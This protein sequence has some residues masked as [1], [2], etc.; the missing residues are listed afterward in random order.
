MQRT[1]EDLVNHPKLRV[2]ATHW[3]SLIESAGITE[4]SVAKARATF[5]SIAS[6]RSTIRSRAQLPDAVCYE[7][8]LSVYAHHK[9][10]DSIKDLIISAIRSG[11]HLTAYVA[12]IVIRAFSSSGAS[13][14]EDA[15]AIFAQMQD[16]P[17]GLAASGNHGPRQRGAGNDAHELE[18]PA[19]P[20]VNAD[21]A[22]SSIYREPSTY[23]EMI[24]AEV[25]HRHF[26]EAKQLL[27]GMKHRGFPAPLIG[28]AA[29]LLAE[30]PQSA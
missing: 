2:Q 25:A 8:L 27:E 15:R 5:D 26:D 16:P 12:N 23:E 9:E 24:R 17:A 21:Q 11:T 18:T 1:F 20:P 22:W 19:A 3:A 6:H 29:S 28:R 4:S 30:A 7:A 10:I 14:L 13:G